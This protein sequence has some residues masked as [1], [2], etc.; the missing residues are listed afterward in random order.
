MLINKCT[1]PLLLLLSFAIYAQPLPIDGV[2]SVNL[3]AML[4]AA[5]ERQ[6]SGLASLRTAS[7]QSA[8]LEMYQRSGF[9]SWWQAPE[10]LA[11][12]KYELTQLADDGLILA[13]YSYA[14]NA[15]PP[16][17]ACDELRVTSEYLLALEHLGF[18]RL[19]AEKFAPQWQPANVV[20]DNTSVL[21][22]LA[23]RGLQDMSAAFD[24]A[25]PAL[26]LY[27]ELRLAYQHM[28]K[29]PA[30]QQALPAGPTLK[31][32]LEDLRIP[33][34][35][36][37]LQAEAYLDQTS[38]SSNKTSPLYYDAEIE[39]AVR[40]FQSD[41]GLQVDSAVGVQTL[42]ALNVSPQQRLQQ[43]RINLERLRWLN[44]QRS[45]YMILVNIAGGDIRLYRDQAIVWQSR[46]MSGRPTRPTPALISRINRI[47]LNPSWTVP[48]TIF[49][50][51]KL[52][53]IRRNRDFLVQNDLHVLDFQGR[54]VNPAQV[55]WN[56]PTGIILRQPPGPTNPLGKLALRFP[57]PFAIYLHDTPSQ[58]LFAKSDRNVSSGCVRVEDVQGL[59]SQLL[60][61]K[62][63][64][65]RQ[66]IALLLESGETHEIS[67]RNGPQ[68]IIT[69]WTAEAANTGRVKFF[70]DPYTL[71]Y[72]LMTAFRDLDEANQRVAQVTPE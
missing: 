63:D 58:N 38:A 25:R 48:P 40:R 57:S 30:P 9:V 55:D 68:L 53:Q 2:S 14:L 56:N 31:P 10:R 66:E 22:D 13:D 17:D 5:P 29:Q 59:T 65:E 61:E 12:L 42:A 71:D 32:G 8:L 60:A 47:T 24:A 44:T 34:L 20:T 64:E 51:D 46:V 1:I 72:A 54:G 4:T 35:V 23:Q 16:A 3:Q 21:A 11:A 6:C 43:V 28:D 70:R 18:G 33:Q 36:H 41:H 19:A 69:Y 37:R 26:P 15:S 67:L 52:P 27:R 49:K 7:A 45:D 62:S 39:Q 50:E